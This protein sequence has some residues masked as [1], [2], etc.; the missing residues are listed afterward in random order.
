MSTPTTSSRKILRIVAFIIIGAFFLGLGVLNLVGRDQAQSQQAAQLATSLQNEMNR[1]ANAAPGAEGLEPI[2][3]KPIVPQAKGE[4]GEVERFALEFLD[5][6]AAQNNAYAAA[7]EATGFFALLDPQRLGNDPTLAA[8][9]A[10]I[11]KTKATVSQ[12]EKLSLDYVAGTG[13]LIEALDL[14]AEIKQAA[15]AGLERGIGDSLQQIGK[16]WELEMQIVLEFEKIIDVLAAT[17]QWSVQDG[18]IIIESET[19]LARVQAQLAEIGRLS[20]QQ[21][22]IRQVSLD[23]ANQVFDGMATRGNR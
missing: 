3:R 14:S 21:E 6:M 19:D 2:E 17:G 5:Q 9:R 16:V 13:A 20:E 12:H 7:I 15:R 23:K 1:V 11:D 10:I 8:S 22:Q 4:Y 18:Q